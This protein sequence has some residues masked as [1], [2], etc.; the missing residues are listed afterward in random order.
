MGTKQNNKNKDENQPLYPISVLEI[1]KQEHFIV[2]IYQRNFSWGETQITQLIEDIE[3]AVNLS[4][5]AEDY[6]LGNLILNKKKKLLEGYGYIQINEVIDGQQRLTTLYL[7]EKYLKLDFK[8]DALRFE[9]RIKSNQT[10]NIIYRD[11]DPTDKGF[12][13]SEEIL[14][15]YK[16]I[17]NYF[18]T[19]KIDEDTFKKKLNKVYLI[20]V[21]V[22]KRIDLNHYFEIMNTRGEQLEVH[23]IAKA[24]ILEKL[25]DD[26]TDKDDQKLAANIWDACSNMNNYV[27]M[28]FNIDVRNK[29]FDENWNN[30]KENILSFD[31]LKET[32]KTGK[33]QDDEDIMQKRTLK[34]RIENRK[35]SIVDNTNNNSIEDESERFDS[36]ISFPNFLLQL[37]AVIKNSV[38]EETSLDDKYFLSNL[39][40]IWEKDEDAKVKEKV[41][42]FIF[43]LLKVRVIFDRIII[44]REYVSEYRDEGKWSLQRM[45]RNQKYDSAYYVA[46]LEEKDNKTL[47][48]LQSAL[49]ITYTSPKTMHWIT[50][51]IKNI[52]N[53]GKNEKEIITVLEN[54]CREKIKESNYQSKS[55]FEIERIV[56]SYLD[57][58]LYRD[59]YSYNNEIFITPA[60][61]W[62]FQF[63]KSIEHFYPQNPIG[64]EK[65]DDEHLDSFG[66]LALITVSGNSLI[67]NR[68]P[69]EK[70]K[71]KNIISQSLKLKIMADITNDSTTKWNK[72]E[73]ENH[74]KE[75]F[76][77][78]EEDLLKLNRN[79]K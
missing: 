62:Q 32:I 29:I 71:V 27:Q 4:E 53:N 49:R 19:E 70:A 18:E 13:P 20:L 54:Y 10:L 12:V 16:I 24:K 60:S 66:N 73:S 34:D 50:L 36:I 40:W 38:D 15:G 65:W 5:E 7:L 2:P 75:M 31:D 35:I 23:E 14:T 44:K 67:S 68:I 22:P 78:I 69:E 46:T 3:S 11:E 47:R 55:G 9:A 45:Q 1:F 48:A 52:I 17:K 76:K 59:G 57:Y 63:R 37:N 42:K 43:Q 21:Q 25:R 28:N 72:E 64:T 74:K 33:T 51:V 39:E 30:L 41:K 61:D 26:D 6:F 56:F 79:I 58:L 8:E 77:I